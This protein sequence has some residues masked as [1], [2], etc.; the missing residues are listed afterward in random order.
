MPRYKWDETTG[1][2]V[3]VSDKVPA[4]SHSYVEKPFCEQVRRGFRRQ[5]ERGARFATR[6]R[7][8]RALWGAA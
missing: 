2:L 7:T 4:R 1:Q 8:A 5:E 3:K 6:A